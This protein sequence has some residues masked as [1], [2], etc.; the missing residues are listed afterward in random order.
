MR[1][2]AVNDLG[3]GDAPAEMPVTPATIPGP[4]RRPSAERGDKSVTVTWQAPFDDGGSDVTGYV[5]EWSDDLFDQSL[6]SQPL[7]ANVFEYLVEGLVNGTEYSVRV[8]AVNDVGQGEAATA[9]PATPASA[10][11][12]PSSVSATLGN[13]LVTVSWGAPDD[14][15][16]PITGYTVQWRDADAH[17]EDSDPSVTVGGD[18]LSRRIGSLTNGTEYFVQ[19]QAANDVSTGPWSA[20]ASATP[21][22]V[23]GPPHIVRVV[24]ASM[25]VTVSWGALDDA[26]RAITGYR[27]QWRPEGDGYSE[28]RQAVTDPDDLSYRIEGLSNGTRYL[29]R[30][31]AQSSVGY[32]AVSAEGSA[33]P[34]TTP[35]APG[36]VT[37]T[38]GDERLRVW[39]DP[40]YDGGS[41]IIDY[42]L[43]RSSDD[44]FDSSDAV[45]TVRGD[46]VNRYLGSLTNGSRYW[47]RM[48]ARNQRGTGPWSS[49]VSE[50]PARAPDA[51]RSMSAD[52]GDE[53]IAVSWQAP[54][55][56][57]GLAV[58]GYAV[59]WSDDNFV[60]VVHEQR[61]GADAM[62]HVVE[63]LTNG[64]R[65]RVRVR[66]VNDAGDGE[67]SPGLLAVPLAVPDEVGA[68]VLTLRDRALDVSWDA[69]D[70]GGTA[71]T[72][73]RIRWSS[74]DH[75]DSSDPEATVS[76]TTLG[77]RI[78]GLTNGSRYWVRV[79]ARNTVG[80][81]QWSSAVSK[82]PATVADAP[83]SVFAARGDATLVVSWQPPDADGG[84]A[85]FEYTVQW[86][87]SG[88][89][90]GT[91]RQATATGTGHSIDGLGNGYEH[92]VQVQAVNVAGTGPPAVTSAV[93]GTVPGPPGYPDF[94][95]TPGVLLM[96]WD[97]PENDGGFAVT[98]YRVQW[99][100]PGE[101]YN[102][103]DRL[104]TVTSP[105]HQIPGLD[106]GTEYTVRVV[107]VNVV[108]PG[109]AV[110]ASAE[111]ADPPGAPN[112]PVVHVR[113]RSL[114]VTWAPPDTHGSSAT[115]H[116]DVLWKAPDQSFNDSPCSHRKFTVRAD[117]DL[118]AVVGPLRN[119]RSYDVRVVAVNDSGPGE[120]ADTSGVPLAVP[121]QPPALGA[122]PTDGD[123][124]AEWEK[125]WDGG[126]PITAYELQWKN[127]DQ[128]YNT[129]R[130]ATITDLSSLS[131]LITG[132]ADNVEHTVRV[133]A[134]N[135]NGYSRHADSTGIPGDAPG[136]P[137]MF[138][139]TPIRNIEQGNW[140]S[141]LFGFELTWDTPSNTGGSPIT[142]YYVHIR[143]PSYGEEYSSMYEVDDI[144]DLSADVYLWCLWGCEG[145]VYSVSVSAIN[146]DG[147]GPPARA[148][149]AVEY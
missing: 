20:A 68:V 139:V 113:N 98:T 60:L 120:P 85:V 143:R 74:D 29:V 2:L 77:R 106:R 25:S 32:G 66:A 115:T 45:L 76:G 87:T 19:V 35:D 54:D 140:S 111:V 79:H 23:P 101:A 124:L 43:Q 109:P 112:S 6:H 104:A 93:P 103:T 138:T 114:Y 89:T 136:R 57:G 91:D 92:W 14:G 62:Q 9:V 122:F 116:Y 75:F 59:Q 105:S 16:S 126:S 82:V 67:A 108:G 15:G 94:R 80:D 125:P 133:R 81:G 86:R 100:G 48:Q 141:R 78:A 58:T 28:A 56:H 73:Y 4:P 22:P 132:L 128:D 17:F 142:G 26:G 42:F 46:A 72:A 13:R 47:M 51:P 70:D 10:P 121:G 117:R 96:S 38:R 41:P 27:V 97:P 135:A 65:Y 130:Q 63:G 49:V 8:L 11:G 95:S 1:V 37:V 88:E 110:E 44:H 39:W 147:L 134:V 34:A 5:V 148:E 24:R 129:D 71:M 102:E 107:A 21:S 18:T 119:D 33:T 64:K 36:R 84:S 123:L 50:V 7:G 144:P 118:G 61:V 137:A 127:P 30:V 146:A 3:D 55:Y 69:P 145:R 31:T 131:H 40:P 52:A 12:V 90:F 53:T 149:T 83:R 99:K